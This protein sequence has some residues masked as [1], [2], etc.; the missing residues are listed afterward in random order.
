[1]P[2]FVPRIISPSTLSVPN[3]IIFLV[4]E[5]FFHWICCQTIFVSCRNP[6]PILSS[7][8][9]GWVSVKHA[10]CLCCHFLFCHMSFSFC[11]VSLGFV[12]SN[13]TSPPLIDEERRGK[14]ISRAIQ[15]SLINSYQAEP[16]PSESYKS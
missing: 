14:A 11:C 16:Q 15:S 3:R 8:G 4:K 5:P 2:I 12:L 6:S 13:L 7:V 10:S 1:M 9:A